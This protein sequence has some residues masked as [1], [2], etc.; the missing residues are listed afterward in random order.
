MSSLSVRL[1]KLPVETWQDILN[2][3][4]KVAVRHGTAIKNTFRKGKAEIFKQIWEMKIKDDI[5]ALEMKTTND[6]I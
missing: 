5:K 3:D 6:C 4:Y 1:P 2:S